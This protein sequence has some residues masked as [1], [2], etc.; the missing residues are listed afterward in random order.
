MLY[1]LSVALAFLGGANANEMDWR[2]CNVATRHKLYGKP[3][4]YNADNV[5]CMIACDHIKT[6]TEY[7]GSI[8][9]DC[10]QI[11]NGSAYGGCA[12]KV[13]SAFLQYFDAIDLSV[14]R[15]QPK[16]LYI[17]RSNYR[18]F[19]EANGFPHDLEWLEEYQPGEVNFN[20]CQAWL[21]LRHSTG[22]GFVVRGLV[23]PTVHVDYTV[24]DH[25]NG[26]CYFGNINMTGGNVPPTALDEFWLSPRF[27]EE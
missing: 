23:P 2:V 26:R 25:Q 21:Q 17:D 10:H 8:V 6:P 27:C 16:S 5:M 24:L 20:V 13:N 1:K 11:D 22:V 18:Q 4:Q 9:K 19:A 14:G 7:W 12:D 15:D 3:D